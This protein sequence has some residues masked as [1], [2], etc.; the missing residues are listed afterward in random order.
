MIMHLLAEGHMEEAVAARLFSFCGHELGRVYGR[1]GFMY[2]RE[3]A[4]QFSH[5]ATQ[6]SGVLVLTDFRDTGAMCFTAALQQYI[7]RSLPDPPGT[8]LC[9]F[10]VNELESWLLADRAGLA[11]FLGIAAA[12]MPHQPERDN[13]PKKTLA[14]LARGSRKNIIRDGIAPPLGH[15]GAVGPGYMPLMREFVTEFWNIEAAT[16]SNAKPLF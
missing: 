13:F 14:A 3:K 4:A 9:R 1:R 6:D 7:W 12:K 10:A 8:F 15:G 11:K 2:I 5:L 16:A